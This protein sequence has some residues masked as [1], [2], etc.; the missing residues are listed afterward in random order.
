MIAEID[1]G[2]VLLSSVLVTALIALAIAFVAR[3]VLSFVGAYRLVWHPAL[4]D[5]ALFVVIW[6]AVAVA[7]SPF[8]L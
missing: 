2:G 3:S 6:T 5:T 8:H 4:F 1:V 7:P